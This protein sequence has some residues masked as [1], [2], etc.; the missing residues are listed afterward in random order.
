MAIEWLSSGYRASVKQTVTVRSYIISLGKGMRE[1]TSSAENYGLVIGSVVCSSIIA[2][3][4]RSYMS[5]VV[6]REAERDY[7]YVGEG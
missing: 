7:D 3:H 6:F 2:A 4:K 1:D 5:I